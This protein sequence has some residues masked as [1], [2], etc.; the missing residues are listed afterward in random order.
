MAIELIATATEYCGPCDTPLN[1]DLYCPHCSVYPR[2][3]DIRVRYSCVN[4]KAE[5][6]DGPICAHCKTEHRWS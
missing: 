1:H 4:C 5:L 6:R 3:E 2:I